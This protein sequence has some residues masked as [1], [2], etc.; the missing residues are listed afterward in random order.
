MNVIIAGGGKFGYKAAV[1]LK[2]I[3]ERIVV[4]DVD[5]KCH[6]SSLPHVEFVVGDAIQYITELM[7][8]KIIP[9]YVIPCLPGNLAAKVFINFMSKFGLKVT[10]D[11]KSFTNALQKI[12]EDVIIIADENSATIVA[13]HAKDFICPSSCRAPKIC[14]ISNKVIHPLYSILNIGGD[15]KI[16]VSELLTEG[17]GGIRGKELYEELIFRVKMSGS[18]YVGTACECHGIVSFLRID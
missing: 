3:A 10:K 18:F 8:N 5:P 13:S 9:D 1:D 2:E 12:K 15:G 16:F 17:V 14:P 11:E 4:V 7:I 6:A